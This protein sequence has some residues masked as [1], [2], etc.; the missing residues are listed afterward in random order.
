[1]RLIDEFVKKALTEFGSFTINC[2]EADRKDTKNFYFL[3]G[4]VGKARYIYG[5]YNWN[6]ENFFSAIYHIK[7]ELAAIVADRT[8]YIIDE[9]LLGATP[10]QLQS[11]G[12]LPLPKHS[13]YFSLE[14][15]EQTEYFNNTIFPAFLDS[16]ETDEIT[17]E[18]QK[19]YLKKQARKALLHQNPNRFLSI[20]PPKDMVT[21]RDV[22]EKLCGLSDFE[23]TMK[24][25]LMEKADYW[26]SEKTN[27]AYVMAAAN[28]GDCVEAWEL[29]LADSLRNCNANYVTVHF[30]YNGKTASGKIEPSRLIRALIDKDGFRDH[31]FDTWNNGEIILSSLNCYNNKYPLRCK[32]IT[33]ITYSRKTLYER[34]IEE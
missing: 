11:S 31:D 33:K 17:D 27:N 18:G 7:P 6:D 14:A 28:K 24:S 15:E 8:V 30:T 23:E 16:L 32:H 9:I 34:K 2:K 13:K 3:Q 12:N 19:E 5:A 25:R 22:A 29:S 1:M 26:K 10:Y 21:G 20:E 4:T